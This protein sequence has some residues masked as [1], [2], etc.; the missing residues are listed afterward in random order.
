MKRLLALMVLIMAGYPVLA[1]EVQTK[2]RVCGNP[3][4]PC[5]AKDYKFTASQLS[6]RLP[7][8]LKWQ[9][10]YYSA[11]FYAVI[12]QSR[13]KVGTGD[14]DTLCRSAFTETERRQTQ[15]LFAANKVFAS[16]FGCADPNVGYTKVNHDYDILAVYAGATKKEAQKFLAQ[17]Q[18][19]GRFS[20]ANLRQMQVV[21]GYGD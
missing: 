16:S 8:K 2:S 4:A 10:N 12:L 5:N 9:T 1:D 14:Q 19:T 20:D 13:R 11:S 7:K 15:Q 21:V 17:V 18:E 6:F 3:S